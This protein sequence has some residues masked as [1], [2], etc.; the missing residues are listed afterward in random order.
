MCACACVLQETIVDSAG[1]ER[2]YRALDVHSVDAVVQEVACACL[3]NCMSAPGAA[4]LSLPAGLSAILVRTHTHTHVRTCRMG[5]LHIVW[6]FS[7][8]VGSRP[9]AVHV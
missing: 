1:L 9:A 7:M 5:D 4:K 8:Y 2:V 6:I 3:S